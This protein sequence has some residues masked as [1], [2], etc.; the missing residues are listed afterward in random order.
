MAALELGEP[1]D[2]PFVDPPDTR[3]INDGYRL[4]QELKAVDEARVSR[5]SAGRLPRCRSIRAW[6]ACCSRRAIMAA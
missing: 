3:L 5:A 6:R 2:F 1:E 4:L